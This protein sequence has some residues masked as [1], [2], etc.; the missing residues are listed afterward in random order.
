[1]HTLAT[2][3]HQTNLPVLYM[4]HHGLAHRTSRE[5]VKINPLADGAATR[6]EF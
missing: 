4:L 5:D 6:D 2:V 3:S 1:M